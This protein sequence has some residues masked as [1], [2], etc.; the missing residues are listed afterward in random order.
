MDEI[1]K[2]QGTYLPVEVLPF[3]TD[4]KLIDTI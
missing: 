1:K 4:G 2:V 3:T